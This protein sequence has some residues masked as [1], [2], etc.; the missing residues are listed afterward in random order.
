M[1]S[2]GSPNRPTPALLAQSLVPSRLLS[3]RFCIYG[4]GDQTWHPLTRFDDTFTELFGYNSRADAPRG[5]ENP[6]SPAG[7]TL[8]GPGCVAPTGLWEWEGWTRPRTWG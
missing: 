2:P 8:T 1:K 6:W 4:P 3:R 5:P 7:A